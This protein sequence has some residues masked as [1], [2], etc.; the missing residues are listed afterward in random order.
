MEA[1]QIASKEDFIEV[2]NSLLSGQSNNDDREN[3]DMLLNN[4]Y[5]TTQAW[6]I[7]K[8]IIS[9]PNAYE[10]SVLLTAAKVLRVKVYY[11]LSELPENFYI[12]MFRLI[13]GRRCSPSRDQSH[14]HEVR[15]LAAR[16]QPGGAVHAHI[17]GGT[18]PAEH[19]GGDLPGRHGGEPE[20]HSRD[21]GDHPG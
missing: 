17:R 8:E 6:E 20:P 16:G 14:R 4:L 13:L 7:T 19:P 21:P 9:E 5:L 15:A 1:G 18:G 3:A 11:Y 2:V 10:K 12:P